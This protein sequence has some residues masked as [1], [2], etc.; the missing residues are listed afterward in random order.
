MN[1]GVTSEMSWLAEAEAHLAEGDLDG[2]LTLAAAAY[3]SLKA[4]GRPSGAAART[5]AVVHQSREDWARAAVFAD[6]ALAELD[7]DEPLVL[8]EALHARAVTHLQQGELTDASPL[9]ERAA[10]LLKAHGVVHDYAA[11]MLTFAEIS[12]A[13][14]QRG[15]AEA[16]FQNVLAE[17]QQTEP[18][19]EEHAS[20][21]NSLTAKAFLGLGSAAVQALAGAEIPGG[22]HPV[23]RTELAKDMLSRA[24]EFIEAAHGAAHPETI[25]VL[26]AVVALYRMLGEDGEAAEVGA[27]LVTAQSMLREVDQA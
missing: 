25:E 23:S 11:V 12:L 14:G 17:V 26:E 20:L 16:V 2:A 8:A 7:E 9:L 21:L 18:E 5:L 10:E 15:D 13:S 6:E 27:R 22:D 19:S 4:A 1:D 3:A 24:V